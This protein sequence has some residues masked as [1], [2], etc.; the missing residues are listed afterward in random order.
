MADPSI[1]RRLTEGFASPAL[2]GRVVLGLLIPLIAL[3]A[4]AALDA[5]IEPAPWIVITL[6]AVTV[7]SWIN[8]PLYGALCVAI[9]LGAELSGTP[10]ITAESSRLRSATPPLEI[11]TAI[12][13]ML[14]GTVIRVTRVREQRSLDAAVRVSLASADVDRRWRILREAID[15]FADVGSVIQ[16]T[17][18]LI[19]RVTELT[20]AKRV[21]AIP[22]RPSPGHEPP[23][24]MVVT[25][26]RLTLPVAGASDALSV[27][28]IDLPA[29]SSLS[30]S[31]D[32]LAA[33]QA[34]VRLAAAALDRMRLHTEGGSARH[35]ASRSGER[36]DRLQRLT[37]ALAA[38]VTPE[39]IG[40]TIV[41]HT[42]EGLGASVG[43]FYV[44]EPG[45][46]LRLAHAR[47]YPIGLAGTDARLRPDAELPAAEAARR[48]ELVTVESQEE[49]RRAFPGTSDRLG[50]TG[51]RSLVALPIGRP[52]T[53]V[54]VVQRSTPAELTDDDMS[55]LDV[56]SHQATQALE[57]SRLY[58]HE[59]EARQLQEAFVGV[60]SHELRTPITTILAGSKL[61]ARDP[62]LG[63]RSRDLAT[64]IEAEADRL[65]RLIE[66]LLVLSRLER[67][68]LAITDDPVHL[69]RVLERVVASEAGR[70]PETR[71]ELPDER[72]GYLVRGDETYI[73][74][75]LRNLLANAAK[76]S[77][78]G[79]TVR[80]EVDS[81]ASDV[82]VRVL[83]EG[84]GVSA[85]EVE[86]LFTLFYRSPTTAASAAGAGIGLFVCRR[87]ID[88]M[89]GHVWARARM[90]GGS[91]F[92]FALEVYPP[93]ELDEEF[94]MVT[95][96][97]DAAL[98]EPSG[99]DASPPAAVS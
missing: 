47:G 53:G 40:E 29:G 24:T 7:A 56:V 48:E 71:F 46:D 44:V 77:P 3:G 82:S 83:D 9:I 75:I 18:V 26:D 78:I 59:R 74:Q 66:D 25:G 68:N 32:D 97:L 62:G 21:E 61:L 37:S 36:L 28:R 16:A 95:P 22:F 81:T 87:L 17:D 8:G 38:A 45:G 10:P 15:E 30:D 2:W 49:W 14:F 33:T 80:L 90:D 86:Q 54:L 4:K 34:L 72:A 27:L 65:F 52:P 73:E 93:D 94:D 91:E 6:F 88:A 89:G 67:G 84:P 41:H 51:T 57:R 23:S 98:S 96:G 85:S 69:V 20:G 42:L 13:G 99:V 76:Y 50:I 19:R 43:L 55:F 79:S 12:I 58:A 63:H 11:V 1:A 60:M 5:A 39:A 35:R 92:G 31:P 64:D 70:W